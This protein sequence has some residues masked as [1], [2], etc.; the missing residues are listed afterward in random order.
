MNRL[1]IFV[2]AGY[3]FAQGSRAISGNTELRANLSLK[4][5]ELISQLIKT[6]AEL[7]GGIPLLRI[8]WYDAVGSRGLTLEQQ[9][10]ASSNNIKMRT[11]TLNAQGQQKGVDSMIVIDLLELS[12]NHAISDAVL[13]TGDADLLVGMQFAQSYGVRTHLIGI[14]VEGA[15]SNQSNRLLNDADTHITW[16]KEVVDTFL[17]VRQPRS[18]PAAAEQGVAPV[19]AKHPAAPAKPPASPKKPVEA[20]PKPAAQMPADVVQA[21]PA[22]A[23]ALTTELLA[24]IAASAMKELLENDAIKL[25]E[26]FESSTTI[27]PEF[28][29]K[30]L[31]H[32]KLNAGRPLQQEEKKLLRKLFRQVVSA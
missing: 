23:A 26:A 20:K 12:R 14:E 27:P 7:S 28:D 24:S 17:T 25:R 11:G 1:G 6:S 8:Y 15:K 5:G 13:V 10:L 32:A 18:K 30:L 29:G 4:E 31:R 9:R 16:P 3:L 19:K 2:D 21:V 22:M